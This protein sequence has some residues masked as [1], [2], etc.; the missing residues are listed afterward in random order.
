MTGLL[1]WLQGWW[2]R[3]RVLYLGYEPS[4]PWARR[5]KVFDWD[6]ERERQRKAGGPWR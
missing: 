5:G 6:R 3:V 1:D 2:I 4:H